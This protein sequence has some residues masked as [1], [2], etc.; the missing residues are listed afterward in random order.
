MYVIPALLRLVV[1]VPVPL[2]KLRMSAVLVSA[3]P[4]R[5]CEWREGSKKAHFPELLITGP[6]PSRH[7]WDT[8]QVRGG[9]HGRKACGVEQGLHGLRLVVALFAEQP[10]ARIQM[11]GR[12]RDDGAESPQAIAAGSERSRGLKAQIA[13]PK[14]RVGG[15]DIGR[16]C[17]DHR[18]LPTAERCV[19]VAE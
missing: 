19:P 4:V 14:M 2:Q 5:H 12:A 3:M 6:S 18:E 16:I 15:G 7:A 10:A 11:S 17:D 9:K 8:R 1:P 13:L